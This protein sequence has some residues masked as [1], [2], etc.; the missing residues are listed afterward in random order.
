MK[1]L[2]LIFLTVFMFGCVDG[3]EIIDCIVISTTSIQYVLRIMTLF[4]AVMMLPMK[5]N[6]MRK[7]VVFH[8]GLKVNV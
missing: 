3:P 6:V 4:V 2:L 8:F 7:K 1:T 5:M